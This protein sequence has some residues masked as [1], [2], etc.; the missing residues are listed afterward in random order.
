MAFQPNVDWREL[1]SGIVNTTVRR[2]PDIDLSAPPLPAQS[3]PA[4][5]AQQTTLRPEPGFG[6]RFAQGVVSAALAGQAVAAPVL[7]A[8]R[9]PEVR[10]GP[11]VRLPVMPQ[12]ATTGTE[13]APGGTTF[14]SGLRALA[15]QIAD[16][17]GVDRKLVRAVIQQES[18]WNPM[19]VSSVGAQGLMQLMPATARLLGVSNPFDP[20]ENIEGGVAFLA[21]LLE[22][23]DGDV[24]LALAAYNA[25]PGAVDMYGGIPP[26][27]QTQAY[28][29]AVMAI[30]QEMGP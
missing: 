22:K 16:A 26:F 2:P 18:R 14:G 5:R 3:A 24:E 9:M 7:P 28:V 15:D 8:G 17:Q 21:W 20:R 30:L 11:A 27:E 23:Y 19:A 6:Q 4:E 13:G 25:G 29:P 1:L 12:A 10:P